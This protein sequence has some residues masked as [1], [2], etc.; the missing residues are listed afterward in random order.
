MRTAENATGSECTMRIWNRVCETD[1]KDTKS[2]SARGGFT[3]VCATSQARRATE[4]WGPYGLGWSLVDLQFERFASGGKECLALIATFWAGEMH[5]PIAADM[6]FR[7][8]DDCYK[9][10]RTAAQSKALAL[11]G[12]SADV[13]L[14]RFDDDHYVQSS[15]KKY[16]EED[17][18][19]ERAMT[20][21]IAANEAEELQPIRDHLGKMFSQGAITK[22]MQSELLDACDQRAREVGE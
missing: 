2:V 10:L 22:A 5:F 9:K 3:A 7:A 17:S 4:I 12:F 16:E 1:P 18:I 21:I 13:F 14:G 6:V 20:A 19:K 15:R 11:L 8:G